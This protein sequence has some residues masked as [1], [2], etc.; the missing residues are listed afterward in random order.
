MAAIEERLAGTKAGLEK[1]KA[2]VKADEAARRTFESTIQDRQQ[3]ISKYRD[4]SLEVKT[5]EQ[6]KAL[7]HEIQF[8]EQD[9]RANEDKIL[10]LMVN[11]EVREKHV[12]AAE[13]K[14]KAETAEI[15]KEKIQARQ[16]TAEDEKQMAEWNAKRETARAGWMP[17]C[18][19][20]MI[21][22][23]STEAPAFPKSATRNAW[24]AR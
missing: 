17:I 20:S 5:N 1:A 11:A 4:Q 7:M 21:G 18:C 15:E 23:Q 2:A 19:A 10:E 6:Y 22:W 16:R 3:K 9:I 12:K 14:L 8:A 13:A 24:P